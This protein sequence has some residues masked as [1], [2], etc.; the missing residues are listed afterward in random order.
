VGWIHC[1]GPR[2]AEVEHAARR[3]GVRK[4]EREPEPAAAQAVVERVEQVSTGAVEEAERGE[5][6]HE[7]AGVRA[8]RVDDLA[9]EAA[10]VGDVDLAGDRGDH[11]AV[12]APGEQARDVGHEALT[13]SEAAPSGATTLVQTS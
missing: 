10:R 4:D 2:A 5:V 9:L 11:D 6:D 1:A 13:P 3:T 12:A 7:A 8:D